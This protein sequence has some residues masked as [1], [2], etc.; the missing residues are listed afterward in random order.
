MG[1]N[2]NYLWPRSKISHITFEGLLM[3]V[4]S[5]LIIDDSWL[6]AMLSEKSLVL[7]YGFEAIIGMLVL[8]PQFLFANSCN[9]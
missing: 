4:L 7:S 5:H 6:F 8:T 2:S 1:Q 9:I 3:A